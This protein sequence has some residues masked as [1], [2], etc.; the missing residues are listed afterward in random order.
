MA[1]AFIFCV[2]FWRLVEVKE[3][4]MLGKAA[5]TLDRTPFSL[6]CSRMAGEDNAV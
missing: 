2:L 3:E 4:S 6:S 1:K 5:R